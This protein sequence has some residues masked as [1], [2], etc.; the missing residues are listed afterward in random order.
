MAHSHLLAVVAIAL[1]AACG[2]TVES[3]KQSDSTPSATP[4]SPAS[5]ATTS[6]STAP[7][8]T[9][10]IPNSGDSCSGDFAG[11]CEYGTNA[12]LSC[13]TVVQCVT[14]RSSCSGAAD[15]AQSL[16]DRIWSVTAPD[17]A[18]CDAPPDT[19]P[20]PPQS[21]ACPAMRPYLGTQCS[22]DLACG[23]SCSSLDFVCVDGFWSE[24]VMSACPGSGGGGGG[25]G[26]RQP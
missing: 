2:G 16:K 24:G 23:Y 8:C 6:V 19:T 14:R 12:R 15:C 1:V 13:N 7:A 10:G 9:A 11:Y 18:K 21:A 17:P 20:I 4:M 22:G 25:G 3:S 5:P 26:A